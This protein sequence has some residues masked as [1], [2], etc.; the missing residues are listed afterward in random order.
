[1]KILKIATLVAIASL[2]LLLLGRKKGEKPAAEVV[3]SDHIFDEEL[4]NE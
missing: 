3:D 2:P 1:M 4:S